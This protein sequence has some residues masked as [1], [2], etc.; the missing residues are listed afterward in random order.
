[1]LMLCSYCNR[2]LLFMPLVGRGLP[3][4]HYDRQVLSHTLHVC[5]SCADHM[6]ACVHTACGLLLGP[7]ACRCLT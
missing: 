3:A 7:A 5:A 6:P 2:L 1:M 4:E